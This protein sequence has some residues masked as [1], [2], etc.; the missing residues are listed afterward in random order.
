MNKARKKAYK[1]AVTKRLLRE[2]LILSCTRQASSRLVRFF[3][4]SIVSP[5]IS[6]EQKLI[7]AAKEKIKGLFFKSAEPDKNQSQPLTQA[8]AAK[9]STKK[10]FFKSAHN[11]VAS[12]IEHNRLMSMLNTLRVAFLTT[13]LR[14]VGVFMLTFGVYSAAIFFLKR[15]V[16][17]SI[18]NVDTDDLC[19][20][21]LMFIVGLLF[22]VFGEKNIAHYFG[23]SRII[24]SLLSQSLGINDS[25][26]A[27]LPQKP[28]KNAVGISFL[29]GS[30]LGVLTLFVSPLKVLLT[31][32]SALILVM[33]FN[34]P[35]MGLLLTVGTLSFAS[36]EI[37]ALLSV[38]TLTSY[39]F[40]W[41]RLKR[42]LRFG[43]ADA[44]MLVFLVFL[45][46][47][48]LASNGGLACGERY[49]I[50][51]VLLYF[52]AKNLICSKKLLLQTFN[53]LCT[54]LSAGLLL[55]IAGSYASFVPYAHLRAAVRLITAEVLSPDMLTLALA[56]TVPFLLA[57]PRISSE[58]GGRIFTKLL[59]VAF[60]VVTD[61]LLLYVSIAVSVLLYIAFSYKAPV[62]TLVAS[63]VLL[64]TSIAF[65]S[66]FTVSNAVTAFKMRSY[67]ASLGMD[68]VF[69]A[70]MWD[71]LA[72]VGGILSVLLCVFALIFVFQRML[73]GS[74]LAK[75]EK[76]AFYSG[77][78]ISSSIVALAGT[79]IFNPISDLR[80]IALVWFVWGLGGA[81]YRMLS[82][83]VF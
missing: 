53:A 33:I 16:S 6:G 26:L 64:P 48:M 29:L 43:K 74:V 67:D 52:A 41:L 32:M 21:V 70:S 4:N 83:E 77:T 73:Y 12:A 14:S 50:S 79:V 80:L 19:V 30:I 59:I 62:G 68:G 72:G 44:A 56:V 25:S 28:S 34:V 60:A 1:P 65:L 78:L 18:G 51:F 10:K 38:S 22:S 9:K 75:K 7:A 71:G 58:K 66:D 39:L 17:F 24:G 55:S 36:V 13:P 63:A 81:V 69:S 35:E 82:E 2:S 57:V 3:E 8:Q 20:A 49:I 76:T 31:V 15:Y 54:G 5:V 61:S 23:N 37:T 40:K 42:N 46:L 45:L 47:F 27:R 11:A